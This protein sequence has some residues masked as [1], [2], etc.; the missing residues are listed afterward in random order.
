M[1]RPAPTGWVEQV[2]HLVYY[3]DVGRSETHPSERLLDAAR[4]VVLEGGARR[5][6]LNAIVA[7]S[8]APK[9]SIYHRFGS[10]DDLFA[11]VWIRAIQRAQAAFLAAVT[12]EDSIEAAVGAALSVHDFAARQRADARLLASVRCEDLVHSVRDP[13]LRRSL[14]ELNRPIEQALA[15]LARRLYGRATRATVE[16]VICAVV[17]LPHGAVRRHLIADVDLPA[18]LRDRLA[19]AV[20]A[21]LGPVASSGGGVPAGRGDADAASRS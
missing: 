13:N 10:A 16:R 11:A 21:A 20:R 5:A 3:E 1:A 14:A 15:S 18:G 6:T 7:A 8:G 19:A 9:G 12:A 17:D 2:D 4:G